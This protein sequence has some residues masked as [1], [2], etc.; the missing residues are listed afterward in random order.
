M[1]KIAHSD[2]PRRDFA[3]TSLGPKAPNKVRTR[4][5]RGS[6]LKHLFAAEIE[7][8]LTFLLLN[9]VDGFIS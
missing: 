8:C 4:C 2:A 5:E 6:Y 9:V 3:R 1:E 7:G